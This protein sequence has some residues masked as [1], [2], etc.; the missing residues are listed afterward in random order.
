MDP[1]YL[2]L[3]PLRSELHFRANFKEN[4]WGLLTAPV[5]LYRGMLKHLGPFGATLQSLRIETASLAD[6]HV[7]CTLLDLNTAIRVRL[8]RVEYDCWKLHEVGAEAAQQVLRATWA[9]IHEADDSIQLRAHIVDLNIV[10]E[11]VGST[12]AQLLSRYVRIP[13]ALG[14]MDAGVAFYTPPI[15]SA[16]ETWVKLVLDRMFKEDDHILIKTTVGC[17]ASRVPLESIAQTVEGQLA[18]VLD[19]IGLHLQTELT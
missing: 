17:A 12:S 3:K 8:D 16:D 13:V 14:T 4:A 1:D 18:R 11:V 9:A 2:T 10:A 15:D 5:P 19:G 6:A 7:S